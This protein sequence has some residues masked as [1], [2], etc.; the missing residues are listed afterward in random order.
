MKFF[1]VF[2]VHEGVC[3]HRR[4]QCGR[5]ITMKSDNQ[6]TPLSME[7]SVRLKKC[8]Y[9]PDS[10]VAKDVQVCQFVILGLKKVAR[11]PSIPRY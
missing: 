4:V 9:C 3:E 5:E 7:H 8:R 10:F 11:L 1:G 6:K 2:Q